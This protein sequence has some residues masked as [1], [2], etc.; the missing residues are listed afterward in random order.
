MDIVD[1]NLIS[2]SVRADFGGVVGC[3]RCFDSLNSRCTEPRH[4]SNFTEIM[5]AIASQVKRNLDSAFQRGNQKGP[6][7]EKARWEGRA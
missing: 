7:M 6:K 2:N 5:P 3:N 1:L 4:F